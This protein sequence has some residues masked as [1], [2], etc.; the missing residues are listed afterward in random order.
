MLPASKEVCL[1]VKKVSVSCYQG[2]V[3]N[4][5]KGVVV[6]TVACYQGWRI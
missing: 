3:S 4:V 2:G 1:M 6:Y 5:Y